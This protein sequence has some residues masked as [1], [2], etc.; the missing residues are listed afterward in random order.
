MITVITIVGIITIAIILTAVVAV[1]LRMITEIIKLFLIS[2]CKR[3]NASYKSA[4]RS[5]HLS[6]RIIIVSGLYCFNSLINYLIFGF[7]N[8]FA[9]VDGITKPYGKQSKQETQEQIGDF[10]HSNAIYHKSKE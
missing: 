10:S 6:Y 9:Y 5:N 2:C 4:S 8:L 7:R 3:N 1:L